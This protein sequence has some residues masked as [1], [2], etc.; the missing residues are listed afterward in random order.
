MKIGVIAG[1][2]DI[3]HP[4]YIE[5]FKET[6][7]HCDYL[8]VALHK[9]PSINN[10]TKLKPILSIEERMEALYALNSVSKVMVYESENELHELLVKEK[11]DVRFIGDDYRQKE[12]TGA[13]LNIPIIYIDRSH[14]WSTTRL[15]RLIYDSFK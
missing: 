6:K 11:P 4:G 13:S 7:N 5:M 2:F 9:D 3:L 8:I 10:E 1:S 15:K 12:F 14:G